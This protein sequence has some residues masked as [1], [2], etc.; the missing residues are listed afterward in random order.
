MN[1]SASSIDILV[2]CFANTNEYEEFL[3]IKDRLAIS[4]KDC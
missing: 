3:N 2:R 1:F 4:I